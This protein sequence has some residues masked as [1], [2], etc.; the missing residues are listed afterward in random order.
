M[1]LLWG[2]FGGRVAGGAGAGCSVGGDAGPIACAAQKAGHGVA[3]LGGRGDDVP[4]ILASGI[5][6]H[7]DDVVFEAALDGAP[8]EADLAIRVA[9]GGFEAFDFG[10]KA[11]K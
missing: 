4:A 1:V 9:L 5:G 6:G 10:E 3:A 11:R 8:L 7:F 2:D